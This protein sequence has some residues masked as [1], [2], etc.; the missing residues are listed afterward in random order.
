MT[1]ATA[2]RARLDPGRVS[3]APMPAVIGGRLCP[4]WPAGAPAGLAGAP[5]EPTAP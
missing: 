2:S 5:S 1:A 3:V 4:S